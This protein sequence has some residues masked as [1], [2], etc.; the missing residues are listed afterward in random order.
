MICQQDHK[1][2]IILYVTPYWGGFDKVLV[3]DFQYLKISENICQTD[4]YYKS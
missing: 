2:E 3:I 1:Q 4:K